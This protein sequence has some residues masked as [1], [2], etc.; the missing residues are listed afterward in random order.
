MDHVTQI[1]IAIFA[2]TGFWAAIN[3]IVQG[4]RER[5]SESAEKIKT[6]EAGVRGLLHEKLIERCEYYIQK[7]CITEGEF[8]DLEEYIYTPYHLLHGNGTGDAYLERVKE[9]LFK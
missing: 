3:S 6:L 7:D 2:S 5:R 8:R 9:L 1:L 4:R